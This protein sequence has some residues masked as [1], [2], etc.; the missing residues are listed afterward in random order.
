MRVQS[1]HLYDDTF[2]QDALSL[3]RRSDRPLKAVAESLDVPVSTLRYWYKADMV[4]KGRKASAAAKPPERDR[5]DETPEE[6][7][8]RLERE[9]ASLRKKNEQLE[10]DRA[11]LK[12]AAAFFVKESE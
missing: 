11:I 7:I 6:K 9:V 12:K 8:A 3:L 1:P 10:M 5:T 4:K 2:K